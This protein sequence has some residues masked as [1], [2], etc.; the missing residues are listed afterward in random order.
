M[1]LHLNNVDQNHTLHLFISPN[2]ITV[3]VFVYDFAIL[4]H[5]STLQVEHAEWLKFT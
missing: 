3:E 4:S 2:G 1:Q 5:K